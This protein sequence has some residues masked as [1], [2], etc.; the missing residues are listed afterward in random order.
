MSV[1]SVIP[2]VVLLDSAAAFSNTHHRR[3]IDAPPFQKKLKY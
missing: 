3:T 2:S 1:V